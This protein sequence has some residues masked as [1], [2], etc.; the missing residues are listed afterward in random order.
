[1]SLDHI[2]H[3]SRRD[4]LCASCG[5][6]VHTGEQYVRAPVPGGPQAKRAFHSKCYAG[7]AGTADG[8]KNERPR[9]K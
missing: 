9:G 1:M 6:T 8:T 3:T 2:T 4:R 7:L 5:R